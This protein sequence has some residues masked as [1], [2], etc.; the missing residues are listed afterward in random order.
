[1]QDKCYNIF[2]FISIGGDDTRPIYWK[3]MIFGYL[4]SYRILVIRAQKICSKFQENIPCN[5]TELYAE[6]HDDKH[7]Q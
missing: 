1:M 5:D 7:T 3:R 4:D 2:D 6:Y